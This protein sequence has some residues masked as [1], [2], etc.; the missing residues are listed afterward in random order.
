MWDVCAD[1]DHIP[2]DPG[3][4]VK[5]DYTHGRLGGRYTMGRY[6]N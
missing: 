4:R 3:K 2:K 6:V 1:T 5:Y